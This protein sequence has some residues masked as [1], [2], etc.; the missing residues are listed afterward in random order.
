MVT[1]G[2]FHPQTKNGP[3]IIDDMSLRDNEAL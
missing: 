2:N 3:E 1:L